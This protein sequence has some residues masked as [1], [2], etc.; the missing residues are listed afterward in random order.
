[1]SLSHPMFETMERRLVLSAPAQTP[2]SAP[3]P[4]SDPADYDLVLTDV[5]EDPVGIKILADKEKTKDFF[6]KSGDL[7]K[8]IQTGTLKVQVVDLKTLDSLVLNISGPQVI[9]ADG[10]ATTKGTWLFYFP[11]GNTQGQDPGLIMISGRTQYTTDSFKVLEGHV[12]DI[13]D[14]LHTTSASPT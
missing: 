6:N 1:M 14:A 8:S 9:A 13:C 2:A 10:T 11:A 7:T 12:V 5:C 4:S 3:P